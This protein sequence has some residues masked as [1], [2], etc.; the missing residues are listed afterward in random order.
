MARGFKIYSKPLDIIGGP[1]RPRAFSQLQ[2]GAVNLKK[3][4]EKKRHQRA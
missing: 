1:P 3:E 4:R 2:P